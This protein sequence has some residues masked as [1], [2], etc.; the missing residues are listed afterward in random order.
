M[1]SVN[2]PSG[3]KWCVH[4]YTGTHVHMGLH[5]FYQHMGSWD[6][7]VKSF[8]HI[9]HPS[10]SDCKHVYMQFQPQSR[11]C[12]TVSICVHLCHM[13]TAFGG[14]TECPEFPGEQAKV[15]DGRRHGLALQASWVPRMT[16][17]L[18]P[19]Q[20]LPARTHRPPDVLVSLEADRAQRRLAHPDSVTAAALPPA[21]FCVL[22]A[23]LIVPHPC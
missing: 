11:V 23:A 1:L 4:T 6:P 2:N 19:L 10:I 8:M 14:P 7:D 12:I 9:P 18:I 16:P 21:P 13:S 17:L 20:A 22:S 15:A 5:L 3:C